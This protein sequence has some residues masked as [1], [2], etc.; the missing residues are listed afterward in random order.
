MIRIENVII[1]FLLYLG[2]LELFSYPPTNASYCPGNVTFTCVGQD[3]S[4][5]L[6]WLINGIIVE[7]YVF[8]NFPDEIFPHVIFSN[9]YRITV[10]NASQT[11]PVSHNVVSTLQ[12]DVSFL[13]NDT[14]SCNVL[15]AWTVPYFI[16]IRGNSIIKPTSIILFLCLAYYNCS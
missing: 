3:V 4:I 2:Q 1:I 5:G 10:T 14:V 15:N 9:H 11:S 7:N 12:G 6:N 13:L 16:K 8:T